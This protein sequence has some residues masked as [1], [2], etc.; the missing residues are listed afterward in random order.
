[1]RQHHDQKDGVLTVGTSDPAFPPY[2]LHNDPIERQ[3]IR[4]SRR[5]CS[6][7]RDGLRPASVDWTFA[8]FN[9]LLP[10]GEDYDFASTKFRNHAR[11]ERAV[12]FSEP[13]YEAANAHLASKT[14]ILL[15]RQHSPTSKTQR[16]ACSRHDA[17][18]R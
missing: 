4:V 17:Q 13:Y 16:S 8:A 6:S 3:G 9:K 1:M 5:L 10:P 12:T 7:W 2:V 18:H 11:R 14:A 15:T